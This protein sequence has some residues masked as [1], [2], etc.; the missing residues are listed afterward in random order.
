MLLLGATFFTKKMQNGEAI[1]AR[2]VRFTHSAAKN[3]GTP[4]PRQSSG[5]PS[6][7]GR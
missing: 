5:K 3:S 7:P 4:R 1:P 2:L 6:T